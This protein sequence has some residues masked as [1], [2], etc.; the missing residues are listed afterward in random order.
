MLRFANV[1]GCL[2]LSPPSPRPQCP[3]PV[4]I[5]NLREEDVVLAQSSAHGPKLQNGPPSSLP[6]LS[7][8]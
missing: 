8:S 2:T 1:R 7:A 4:I 3:S 6:T 5:L